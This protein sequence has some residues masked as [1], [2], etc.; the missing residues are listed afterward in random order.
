[1]C[2]VTESFSSICGGPPESSLNNLIW[3][4]SP[5]PSPLSYFE[6]YL[7]LR[8]SALAKRSMALTSQQL[9]TFVPQ[10]RRGQPKTFLPSRPDRVQ[11]WVQQPEW[12]LAW[13][14][15]EL[16][17]VEGCY[18]LTLHLGPPSLTLGSHSFSLQLT[19]KY[20]FSDLKAA[21]RV[22]RGLS[23][24]H[25]PTCQDLHSAAAAPFIDQNGGSRGEEMN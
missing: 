8:T 15:E 16:W 1:M 7:S 11:G 5:S 18:K 14:C 2:S 3:Y 25:L 12:G 17:G 23:K 4:N 19:I 20:N 13:V 21:L 9:Q 10:T 6:H 24:G 22:H